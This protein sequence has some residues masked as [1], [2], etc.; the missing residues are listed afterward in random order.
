MS[1]NEQALARMVD[2]QLLRT[3]T[4]AIASYCRVLDLYLKAVEQGASPDM[5]GKMG[6]TVSLATIGLRHEVEFLRFLRAGVT[7]ETRNLKDSPDD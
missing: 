4:A 2:E 6:E 3:T 7:Q 1:S 5:T